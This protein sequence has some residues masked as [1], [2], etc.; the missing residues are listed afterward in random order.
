M[1]IALV[2]LSTE[3]VVFGFAGAAATTAV[4]PIGFLPDPFG[5]VAGGLTIVAGLYLAHRIYVALERS[6][7]IRSGR[8][9]RA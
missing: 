8:V 4:G 5:S 1:G 2:S 9:A 6:D 7:A 3:S